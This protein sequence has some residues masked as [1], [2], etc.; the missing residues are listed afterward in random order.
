MSDLEKT[1]KMALEDHPEDW[2][3]RWLIIEKMLDRDAEDEASALALDAPA[4]PETDAEMERLVELVREEAHPMVKTYVSENPANGYGHLL[5]GT[6]LTWKGEEEMAQQH[7]AVAQ[8]LEGGSSI[9]EAEAI[10]E[11]EGPDEQLFQA[12]ETGHIPPPPPIT[13]EIPMQGEFGFDEFVPPNSSPRNGGKRATAVL[14]AVGVHVL[15][16][17]I[18]ALVVILPSRQEEPEIVAAIAPVSKKK[19]EMQKKNVVKQT[20]KTSASA[21]AA[22]PLAQLMRANAVAKISMPTITKTSKGPLGIGEADF[23]SGGFGSGGDGLG[24]GASFFGG[25]STGKRFLF[26]IDHSGSM[27]KQQVKLRNDELERALKSLKGVQYQVFLFA[28]GGYYADEGWSVKQGGVS[29]GAQRARDNI[30]TGP[31]GSYKFVS[32][33]EHEDYE[34]QGSDSRLPK[35]DWLDATAS[36]VKKTIKI[37]GSHNLFGGTDWELALRIGHNME[38]PPDVI[39]FMSDGTG[40]NA[41][42]PILAVNKKFGKPPINTVAMQTTRGIQQFAEI[43]KR[44]DASFTIVDKKGEPIDG[45][46]YIKNPGKY[47]G[48]L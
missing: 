32:K 26:V 41:P 27:S 47:K 42:A 21:A 24:M 44:T 28:G 45:F 35:A 20:K 43:A 34:L 22:A 4:P 46:D 5:L 6:V 11:E 9:E 30:V 37:V 36:N 8:A 13:H 18:L 1:L 2:S 10:A 25:T 48:R 14:V 19:Q 31:K 16:A 33:R 3:V 15:V 29:A 38:P 12:A 39:F 17:V 40:G 7:F 23:G